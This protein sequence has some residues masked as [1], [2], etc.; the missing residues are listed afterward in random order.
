M[1]RHILTFCIRSQGDP[2]YDPRLYRLH[3][4]IDGLTWDLLAS[5]HAQDKHGCTEPSNQR[6]IPEARMISEFPAVPIAILH[7]MMCKILTP[8][9]LNRS[10]TPTSSSLLARG[11]V[12]GNIIC[13]SLRTASTDWVNFCQDSVRWAFRKQKWCRHFIA[14]HPIN[15]LTSY[16]HPVAIW[17]PVKGDAPV[18]CLAWGLL[19]GALLKGVALIS[20]V[21][22]GRG[23]PFGPLT[24][25]DT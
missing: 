23:L 21:T 3:G 4:S 11:R 6:P 18:Q 8:Y 13:W 22:N 2:K 9:V 25:R 14:S 7:D 16:I 15:I 19:I 17:A 20:L 24:V 10:A 1:N 5:S 12:C